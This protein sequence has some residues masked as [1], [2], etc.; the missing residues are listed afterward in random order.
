MGI[1]VMP[2]L[3]S[4]ESDM[5]TQQ[6][7]TTIGQARENGRFYRH[8]DSALVSYPVAADNV[9]GVLP[10]G[11]YYIAIVGGGAAGIASLY[12]LSRLAEQ[13]TSGTITV[14]LY[15]SDPDSF[16]TRKH[17]SAIET[18]DVLGLKAGRV[19]AARVNKNDT[20]YEV[21]AMR[22]PE[23]AG[24]TW[25]YASVVYGDDKPI[26]VFPNPGKVATEFMFGDRIDRYS[27]AA[28]EEWLDPESPARKVFL[29]VAAGLA[30]TPEEG[31]TPIS[32]FPIGGRDPALVAKRLKS[33]ET[34]PEELQAIQYQDWPA[35]IAAHDG[36]TLEAAVRRI[37][38]R[39][40]GKGGASSLRPIDGLD[41]AETINYY[42]E[43]FGRFGFGTGGF[44]PLFNMSLVEMMRLILW[45][46]S[47]EYTLPVEE[48]VQFISG[49]YD[50]ALETGGA[51]LKVKVRL[52]QV[53]DTC[54]AESS[55]RPF[56]VSY[57]RGGK[58]SVNSYDYVI[59]AAPQNQLA[60][61]VS[62]SGYSA[63]PATL[64]LG[65][66]ALGRETAKF[67]D[68]LPPLLLSNT[69]SAPNARIVTALNQLHMVRSS[70]VFGTIETAK[71]DDASLVPR[72]NG[73]PIKA[74]VSD[75]GLAASYVVPS[76]T[77]PDTETESDAQPRFS[78]FLASYTWGDDSTRLQPDFGDY[79]Q[80]PPTSSGTASGMFRTMINRAARNVLDPANPKA[81]PSVWWF[82]RLLSAVREDDRFVFDWSTNG[83]AGGFKLDSTGDH[84]QSNLCFRYHTHAR[85]PELGNRFFLASDSY[86]HLGGWLEG[87]FMSAIN[88]VSG[89]IVAANRGETAA[90]SDAARPVVTGLQRIVP[91]AAE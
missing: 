9:L 80:N 53:S 89:L 56:I 69:S 83:T 88:A 34:Q 13:L 36:T 26:K 35:F 8:P 90:L 7:S 78:S 25:H 24:L 74:V 14:T 61:A 18:I 68:G 55:R 81:A 79:P 59:L 27:G 54:H 43:L 76:P 6:I 2:G 85:N 48:N 29:T 30:G 11:H 38:T 33:K 1:T 73:Q 12:E 50:K 3:T 40:I 15:E 82:S 28:A 63:T 58:L 37:V 52:E 20:V 71:L 67:R 10:D 60:L 84:H 5:R 17:E 41:Q 45:D 65:D 32:L 91:R 21:G 66:S 87:A 31:T 19:S 44:K 23:I 39:E 57:D 49:L 77:D 47:N 4:M 72:F 22:F 62:R 64:T 70:K 16:L 51:R 75:S 86:S 42:V 46:Y